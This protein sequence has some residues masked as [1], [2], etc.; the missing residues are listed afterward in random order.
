M[1]ERCEIR[2]YDGKTAGGEACQRD[3]I[4]KDAKGRRCCERHLPKVPDHVKER[5]EREARKGGKG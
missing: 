1:G 3:A 5:R 2:H 4:G